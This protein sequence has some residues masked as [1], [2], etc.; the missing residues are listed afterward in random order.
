MNT[1]K[2]DLLDSSREVNDIRLQTVDKK[3]T[4]VIN[5]ARV[6]VSLKNIYDSNEFKIGKF[7]QQQAWMPCDS[8]KRKDIMISIKS[9]EKTEW[10]ITPAYESRF[11][12]LSSFQ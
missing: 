2:P 8:S 7:F 12:K 1:L 5:L 3:Q 11:K 6:M 4:I 9:Q 10:D